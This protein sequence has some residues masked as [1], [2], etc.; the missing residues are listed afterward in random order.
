MEA[1]TD[2]V[3]CSRSS[4]L[5]KLVSSGA[6]IQRPRS[7]QQGPPP[8]PES[9]C[10]SV[11]LLTPPLLGAPVCGN[12]RRPCSLAPTVAGTPHGLSGLKDRNVFSHDF[13]GWKFKI[14]VS[15]GL[16]SSEASPLGVQMVFSPRVYMVFPLCGCPHLL[17]YTD[18]SWIGL[19]PTLGISC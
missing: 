1:Q 4:D 15:A 7:W 17:S 9:L 18:T 5:E 8:L 3:P 2:G 11:A 10:W 13:V 14:E 6:G 19:G 16:V 12:H